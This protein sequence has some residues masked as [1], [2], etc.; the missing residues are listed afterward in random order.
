[1]KVVINSEYGGFSLSP[2]AVK[3]LAE[4]N[5]KE[6]YFFSKEINGEKY[7][8]ITMEEANKSL[9]FYAFSIPNPNER[10][11]NST[12]F[13][14]WSAEK[15]RKHNELYRSLSLEESPENRADPNLIKVVEELGEEASG[16]LSKL[17]IVEI[18][19]GV[20]WTI[21]EHDGNEWVA[22]KHRTWE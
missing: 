8:L 16:R 22:E 1:M 13:S 17:K 12:K 2:K 4:L 21:E 10:I 15:R 19:D 11:P 5:G 9:F 18:P 3:R 7:N 20:E 6:C 14:S